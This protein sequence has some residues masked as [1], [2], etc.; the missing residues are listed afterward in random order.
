M[1]NTSQLASYQSTIANLCATPCVIERAVR[2]DDD[3]GGHKYDWREVALANCYL[4]EGRVQEVEIA[5]RLHKG[6]VW[7]I[8][9]PVG[10]DVK[11]HDR[12]TVGELTITVYQSNQGETI[13]GCVEAEGMEL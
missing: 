1:L 9:L 10:S 2:V 5:G 11:D 13:V 3:M 8:T 6:R 4:E 12:L 7:L